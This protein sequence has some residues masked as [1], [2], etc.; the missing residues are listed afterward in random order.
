MS[1]ADD[2]QTALGCWQ[3]SPPSPRPIRAARRSKSRL[4]SARD[5][6]FEPATLPATR[7]S[8]EGSGQRPPGGRARRRRADHPYP[9]GIPVVIPGELITAPLLQYLRSGLAAG[10]TYLTPLTRPSRL[11]ASS[12]EIE[13]VRWRAAATRR[14][15][16]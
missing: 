6:E 11:S 14:P 12:P 9:P 4:P 16:S 3:R 7:S 13:R 8:P 2:D 1:L 10:C 15:P 5:L